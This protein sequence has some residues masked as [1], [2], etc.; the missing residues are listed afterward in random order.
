MLVQFQ[1][2]DS[3]TMEFI[4]ALSGYFRD[5]GSNLAVL[6]NDAEVIHGSFVIG[7]M[8]L[9]DGEVLLGGDEAHGK[10][11]A[12]QGHLAVEPGGGGRQRKRMVAALASK[13]LRLP[14]QATVPRVLWLRKD[15]KTLASWTR[16]LCYR[17]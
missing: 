9:T 6:H 7:A 12:V 3:S 1:L 14:K 2:L 11:P 15:V 10:R 13:F 17:S 4:V 5:L 8:K 16:D